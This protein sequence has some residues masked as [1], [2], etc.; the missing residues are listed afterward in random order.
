MDD[1]IPSESLPDGVTIFD[2]ESSEFID[3][4]AEQ[5]ARAWM[6]RDFASHPDIYDRIEDDVTNGLFVADVDLI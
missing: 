4:T 2:A 6:L 5:W 1:E 3:V